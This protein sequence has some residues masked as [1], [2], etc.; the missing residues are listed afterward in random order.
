MYTAYVQAVGRANDEGGYSHLAPFIEGG[1]AL[2]R[3][4]SCLGEEERENSVY[5]LKIVHYQFV[6]RVVASRN[7]LYLAPWF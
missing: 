2:S 4:R 3:T 7:P 6:E 5:V 1:F